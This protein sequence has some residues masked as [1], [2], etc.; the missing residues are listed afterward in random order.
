M[1]Y[2]EAGGA[3][4]QA[5]AALLKCISENDSGLADILKRTPPQCQWAR[6]VVAGTQKYQGQEV[7][8]M[9]CMSQFNPQYGF[10]PRPRGGKG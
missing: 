6:G 10:W 9:L 5:M 2:V 3:G 7:V 8:L 4:L 1:K